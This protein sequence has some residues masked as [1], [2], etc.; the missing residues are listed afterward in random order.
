MFYSKFR[1]PTRWNSIKQL[2]G[3]KVHFEKARGNAR[4]NKEYC[5]KANDYWEHGD[6]GPGQG[7]RTD[8]QRVVKSIEDGEKDIQ[9]VARKFPIE[10]I[11]YG[12]GIKEYIRAIH[13]VKERDFKTLV[14][15][16]WGPPGTGKSKAAKEEADLHGGG[17]YYK[18]RG[19]WWDGYKQQENVIIDDFYGWIKY[20]ELLKITDRYPYKVPVKGG[21]EE[22][23]SK[24]IWIT[25][26]V[27]LE[28]LYKFN[29]YNDAAIRRRC[30]IIRH[31]L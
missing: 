31:I 4:Q 17:T 15:Y 22:F 25:S 12:R 1:G 26:N 2:L 11:K 18:P 27:P 7:S 28:E 6:I 30:T 10:F 21:Y 8:L 13:P 23:T 14:Y 29:N 9:N 3:S 16:Y 24:R 19:E 5:S 20:D